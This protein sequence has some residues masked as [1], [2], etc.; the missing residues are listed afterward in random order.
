MNKWL[1]IFMLTFRRK[2][3]TIRE[4]KKGI[5]HLWYIIFKKAFY[6]NHGCNSITESFGVYWWFIT[7]WILWLKCQHC[8]EW[9]CSGT[10]KRTAISWGNQQ[11]ITLWPSSVKWAWSH[12]FLWN[13]S[14]YVWVWL[15]SCIMKANAVYL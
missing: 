12:S 1:D 7:Y 4:I 9:K 3:M 5:V 10:K 13:Q 2:S 15:I 11:T 6:T 14:Q 8:L